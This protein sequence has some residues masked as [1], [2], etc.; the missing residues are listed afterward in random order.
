VPQKTKALRD[1]TLQRPCFDSGIIVYSAQQ[2]KNSTFTFRRTDFTLPRPVFGVVP[3]G[4]RRN[5]DTNRQVT[6]MANEVDEQFYTRADAHIHLSN[7]QLKEA[8]LIK[9][10]DSMMYALVR[11]NAWVSASGFDSGAEM[12]HSKEE[13][14]E[15]FSTQYR[16]MLTENLDNY[17]ANF[18]RYMAIAK[19]SS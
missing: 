9:V 2:D 13:I 1:H 16:T 7:E 5:N 17:I 6:I 19:E 18:D 8:G 12:Q 4:V 3:G 11:F 15:F 10:N 14:I